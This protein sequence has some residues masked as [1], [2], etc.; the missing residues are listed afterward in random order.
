MLNYQ[1]GKIYTIRNYTDNTLIYVGSTI[2]TLSRRLA[3]HRIDC[4]ANK[5]KITLYSHIVNND[6]A[7]WYI[8]LYEYYSCNN[9]TELERREGQVIREI[10]SINK[11][12]AGRTTKEYHE[13]NA[14][15]VKEYSKK[16]YEDNIDKFKKYYEDNADKINE[17]S[18][19]YQEENAD[20]IKEYW[21]NYRKNNLDKIKE[22]QQKKVCCDICGLF[23]CN[24]GL[25]R[26][27]QTKKCMD[28]ASKN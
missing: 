5:S 1:D 17:Y 28:I 15:K 27:Q 11:N 8:E 26:H 9:R 6:W 2:D 4:K 10:G 14:D 24:K 12:I 25:K 19:K 23:V 21:K 16:Y 18:K 20:K 22:N 3:K 7:N 13:E